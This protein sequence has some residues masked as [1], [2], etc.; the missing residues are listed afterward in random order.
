M[1]ML[2]ELPKY[3]FRYSFKFSFYWNIDRQFLTNILFLGMLVFLF[4]K[5]E[6][7][8]KRRV[9]DSVFVVLSKKGEILHL[10]RFIGQICYKNVTKS[11]RIV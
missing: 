8:D 4:R 2:V 1:G 9:E 10:N 7:T 11:L 5:A 6:F 3:E